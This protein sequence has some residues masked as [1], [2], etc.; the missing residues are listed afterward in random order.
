MDPIEKGAATWREGWRERIADRVRERGFASVT[1]YAD[2][3]PSESLGRLASAL[4]DDVASVQIETLLR[5]EAVRT[6]TVVPFARSLLVR[7][8]A[9]LL[10]AG[11]GEPG[12]YSF[13]RV[14]ALGSWAADLRFFPELVEAAR[15]IGQRMAAS[16]DIPADWRPRTVDDPIL[17]DFFAGTPLALDVDR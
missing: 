2:A 1:A 7:Q 4:G 10:P 8:V 16:K 12:S 15:G 9:E 5:E 11:W 13:A 14:N 6:G 3:A 17:R